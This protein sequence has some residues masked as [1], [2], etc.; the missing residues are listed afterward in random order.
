MRIPNIFNGY[1]RDGIRLYNDPATMV[2]TIANMGEGA[3]A[4]AAIAEAAAAAAAAQA[5][6][7][8]AAAAEAATTA[9]T[10]A[11]TAA[12]ILETT[13]GLPIDQV[14]ALTQGGINPAT[15]PPVP[16]GAP[17]PPA[18]PL[19]PAGGTPFT[20]P[21]AL[22]PAGPLP[23][24]ATPFT[25]PGALPPSGNVPGALNPVEQQLSD[26]ANRPANPYLDKTFEPL[27]DVGPSQVVD[28]APAFD[29][30][31]LDAGTQYSQYADAANAAN[32]TVKIADTT[33][34]PFLGDNAIGRGI[35]TAMKY[36]KEGYEE[37]KKA[38]PAL[39][40]LSAGAAA[41]QFLMDEPEG[42][43]KT[44]PTPYKRT[45]YAGLSPNFK[46]GG[47]DSN[48]YGTYAPVN[49]ANGGLMGYDV[50]GP[51][52]QMSNTNAGIMPTTG[53][54]NMYPMSQQ[55]PFAYA[56]PSM[57]NPISQN[58]LDVGD[59]NNL[60]PYTGMQRF[61]GGGYAE[62]KEEAEEAAQRRRY[63]QMMNPEIR[64]TGV[65]HKTEG[66][67]KGV[68]SGHEIPFSRTQNTSS[69]A[70]AAKSELNAMMKQ[71]GIRSALPKVIDPKG[72][73][74]VDTELAANGGIMHGLGGYSDG[75]RLLRGPG[76]GVSDSIPA[77]IGNR[78]P[79]RLADG[80]FV[81]PARIVSELGNGSTEAGARQLYAMMER[82]QH[83][84]KKS[85]GKG[86]VAVNSKAAKHLPA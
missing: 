48:L 55:R 47:P 10:A 40:Y 80:E 73:G 57:Q 25:P 85:V 31:K 52:E 16:P 7:E 38:P 61:S 23:P 62:D 76:D 64:T 49:V 28:K 6:A 60:D 4:A 30:T 51:V 79:A 9:A 46:P 44:T 17:L 81:I 71:F 69:A 19:P 32:N 12:P 1:S 86:K 42:A 43:P 3:A 22:P 21:G 83:G 54:N 70:T 15:V 2:V 67:G 11:K 84:R 77:Q 29:P 78:Q 14:S 45:P 36:V 72:G 24:A 34:K 74:V 8:T 13:A 39:Q 27:A 65:S 35:E 33:N 59:A 20:V 50:G 58:V 5:A 75:G 82:V 26:L 63:A 68:A 66:F 37:Y 53:Q 41:K 18:T 56:N